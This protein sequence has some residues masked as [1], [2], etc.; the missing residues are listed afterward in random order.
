MDITFKYVTPTVQKEVVNLR[1]EFH[2]YPEEGFLEYLTSGKIADY[3]KDLGYRVCLGDSVCRAV[4]RM[5]MPSP[6]KILQS[7]EQA[8]EEGLSA[9]YL[10]MMKGGK[11]GVIGV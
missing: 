1:R 3:L 4:S 7:E 9:E 11:T 5:G 10:E 2:K 8:F 6:E